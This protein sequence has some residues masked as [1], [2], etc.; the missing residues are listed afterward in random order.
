MSPCPDGKGGGHNTT[1]DGV[2]NKDDTII[3][4]FKSSMPTSIP[5]NL[6]SC[7]PWTMLAAKTK[8]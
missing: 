3:E 7:L 2:E 1:P 5:A 4:L 6:S 8:V